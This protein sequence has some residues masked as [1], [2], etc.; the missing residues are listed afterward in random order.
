MVP[1]LVEVGRASTPHKMLD[2]R[3]VGRLVDVDPVGLE[4]IGTRA[5]AWVRSRIAAQSVA[6]HEHSG[7]HL[8]AQVK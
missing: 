3:R 4:A 7:V 6:A 8:V 1:R 5:T 2:G